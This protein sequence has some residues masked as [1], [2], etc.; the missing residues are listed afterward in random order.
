MNSRKLYRHDG[1]QKGFGDGRRTGGKVKELYINNLLK[2]E[3]QSL[4]IENSMEFIK[5]WQEGFAEAVRGI[6]SDMV[7]RDFFSAESTYEV[8]SIYELTLN[9]KILI[10]I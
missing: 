1:Y 9:W 7:E 5:G 6:I 8:E 10:K 3:T 2:D 4:S